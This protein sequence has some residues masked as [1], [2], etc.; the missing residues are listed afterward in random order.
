LG[1]ACQ[2]ANRQV[3]ETLDPAVMVPIVAGDHVTAKGGFQVVDGIRVF[4]A[5]TLLVHSPPR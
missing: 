4:W 1:V 3:T 5:H 2:G